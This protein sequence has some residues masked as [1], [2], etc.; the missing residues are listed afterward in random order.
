MKLVHPVLL[1]VALIACQSARVETPTQQTTPQAR[2]ALGVKTDV[3][4]EGLAREMDLDFQVRQ[5]GRLVTSVLEEGAAHEAGIRSGDVLLQLGEVTLYSQDDIDDFVSVH[6]PGDEV[7]TTV[8]RGQSGEREDLL[9]EL[10]TGAARSKEAIEWQYASLAQLP[11]ALEQARAEKKK[12]L[13]GLSGAE[14]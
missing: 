6:E 4:P 12:V 10:G 13:V 14:T 9:I 7:S 3:P 1:S 2:A 8:V 5:Q 11:A